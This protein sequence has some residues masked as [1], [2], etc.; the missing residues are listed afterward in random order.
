[1]LRNVN[2]VRYLMFPVNRVITEGL[3]YL[4][5]SGNGKGLLLMLF[6][7]S[8]LVGYGVR[9]MN[10]KVAHYVYWA[11]LYLVILLLPLLL[12]SLWLTF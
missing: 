10:P 3:A 9:R 6:L 2:E 7:V 12:L 11:A 8:G 1:M 5:G 4:A